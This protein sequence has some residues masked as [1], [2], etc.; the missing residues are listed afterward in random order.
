MR[1]KELYWEYAKRMQ[2]AIET[3]E[4]CDTHY[5]PEETMQQIYRNLDKYEA[6]MKLFMIVARRNNTKC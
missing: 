4:A 2:F 6:L 1:V 3:A 5:I